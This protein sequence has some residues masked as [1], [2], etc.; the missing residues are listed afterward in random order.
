MTELFTISSELG[1]QAGAAR[2]DTFDDL[3]IVLERFGLQR[4]RP[5][6]TLV[7]GA[8]KM[9][10]QDALHLQEFF[11]TVARSIMEIDGAIV[12]G[13]TNS[14]I[15]KLIDQAY[16]DLNASFPLVGVAP[17]L[18][19]NLPHVCHLKSV[20]ST[21]AP[22]HTH[23]IFVPGDQWGAESPWL[24]EVTTHL[25]GSLR[26][27]TLVVNGGEVTWK[28]M[29]ASIEVQRLTLVLAGSG[30]AADQVAAALQGVSEDDRANQIVA[31]G[32]VKLI[33]LETGLSELAQQIKEFL[34][35]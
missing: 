34:V 31:S 15:M 27:L 28:D 16:A 23:F 4:T 19:V 17:F 7:G 18:K 10:P 2:V 6:L 25:A 35:G 32:L 26:S 14:G 20:S 8:D 11:I 9:A 1:Q 24:T 5:T 33:H 22:H 21:P 30:R 13:G 12:D 29:L 3:P